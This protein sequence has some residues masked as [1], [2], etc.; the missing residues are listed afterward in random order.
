[1]LRTTQQATSSVAPKFEGK[2]RSSVGEVLVHG[3]QGELIATAK[4][5][6]YCI[7]GADLHPVYTTDVSDFGSTYVIL[8][9]GLNQWQSAEALDDCICRLGTAK[10]LEK[11]LQD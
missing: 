7:N 2:V 9:V 6:Q 3:Q 1:M 8:P 4:L 10:T 11:L 5:Y